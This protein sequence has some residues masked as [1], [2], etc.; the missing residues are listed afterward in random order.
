[1]S[2]FSIISALSNN[3]SVQTVK[4]ARDSLNDASSRNTS[5]ARYDNISD[6]RRL[7]IYNE[8]C[9][10]LA[11]LNEA[12]QIII[13]NQRYKSLTDSQTVILENL[14]ERASEARATIMESNIATTNIKIDQFAE[15]GLRHLGYQMNERDS[16]G[17]IFGGQT[18]D[19][20]PI[21]D[22]EK[23][24]N[25]SNIF[26][27]KATANYTNLVA[28]EDKVKIG[29][30]H[31]LMIDIDADQSA[32]QKMTA[33]FHMMKNID[34]APQ[35]EKDK[36]AN[37]FDD[38]I[39]EINDL[40]VLIGYRQKILDD[41]EDSVSSSKLVLSKRSQDLFQKTTPE[42][43]AESEEHQNMLKTA[44]FGLVQSRKAAKLVDYF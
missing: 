30:S 3:P 16:S 43:I 42:M 22:V 25:T 14:R 12:E 24:A 2:D 10:T 1:M 31:E 44:I 29:F 34:N 4:K 8:Y 15:E 26:Q 7:G 5:E 40:I 17:Y 9:S 38:A 41:A 33:A 20:A 27:G 32:F 19:R 37:M 6:L 28:S 35:N 18:K 36:A 11:Q 13:Q 21:E 39:N 23:F